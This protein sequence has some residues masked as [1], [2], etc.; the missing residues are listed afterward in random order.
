MKIKHGVVWTEGVSELNTVLLW[1]DQA[2]GKQKAWAKGP[3]SW[4]WNEDARRSWKWATPT[5]MAIGQ[6]SRG[7]W[8]TA[9]WE[10]TRRDK[11]RL[12]EG[13][14]LTSEN[15]VTLCKDSLPILKRCSRQSNQFWRRILLG[16]KTLSTEDSNLCG[17]NSHEC[18]NYLPGHS[19]SRALAVP[20]SQIAQCSGLLWIPLQSCC[21]QCFH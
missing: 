14:V 18:Q 16:P 15:K 8:W 19:N 5:C 13:V 4:S 7:S 9:S 2:L 12:S 21:R 6:E 1:K 20:I 3:L 17:S 11:H 10:R